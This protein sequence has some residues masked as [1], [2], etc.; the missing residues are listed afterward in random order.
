MATNFRGSRRRH[1][2][3]QEEYPGGPRSR[4]RILCGTDPVSRPGLVGLERGS[5]K[6]LAETILRSESSRLNGL[7][8]TGRRKETKLGRAIF[9]WSRPLFLRRRKTRKIA[10]LGFCSAIFR[11]S[12][13]AV[14]HLG[15]RH[16]TRRTFCAYNVGKV[17]RTGRAAGS[18]TADFD[19]ADEPDAPKIDSNRLFVERT[20]SWVA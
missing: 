1:L 9:L 17:T 12:A 6:I 14:L 18:R 19:S 2:L 16:G 7:D 4:Q 8:S 20:L 11:D 3:R 5:W 15:V 13:R 10:L